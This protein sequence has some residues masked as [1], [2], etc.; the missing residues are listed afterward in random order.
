MRDPLVLMVGNSILAA[1]T[2]ELRVSL[3]SDGWLMCVQMESIDSLTYP[4]R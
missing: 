4:Q 1:V 2:V 3:L